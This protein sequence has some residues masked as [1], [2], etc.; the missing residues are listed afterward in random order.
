M[1]AGYTDVHVELPLLW[2]LVGLASA[3]AVASWANMRV[4]TYKLPLAA[5]VLVFGSSFVLA[6]VFPA[7]FQRVYV[8]PNELQLEAPYIQRNIALTQEA[9]N[10]RQITVKPFPAEQGL[11]F[12]SLQDNRATI[13][14]IRL[15]DWQ[16]LMDTYAQLQEIRTYYKFHD[17]DVDRYELDGSY[18][19]VMLSARELEPTLLPPTPRPGST[20]ICSSRTATG[21]SCPRSP[22]SPPK[23]CRFSTCR[24]SLRSRPAA[25]PSTSR[26]SIS[27][28]APTPT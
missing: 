26:A 12:Q 14:N 27:G 21:W 10:L 5:A 4:R 6:L 8:K 9:Y 17:V 11:T 16:P 7:L 28:R 25:P 19:Q 13:D 15:W 22:G 1:G 23:G 20:S 3:A 24:T 2:A 18:Q